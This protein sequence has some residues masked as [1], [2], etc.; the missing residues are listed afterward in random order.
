MH[1]QRA[2]VR[3][4]AF[5]AIGFGVCIED[6]TIFTVGGND[7][8]NTPLAEC[9]SFNTRSTN[10]TWIRLPDLPVGSALDHRNGLDPVD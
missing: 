9:Y 10:G 4:R 1:G 5:Q 2:T 7:L 8:D 6:D 3:Y